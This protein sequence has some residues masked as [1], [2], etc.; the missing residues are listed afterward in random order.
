MGSDA[1]PGSAGGAFSQGLA[2]GKKGLFLFKKF[3]FLKTLKPAP[4]PPPPGEPAR[5]TPR[6]PPAHQTQKNALRD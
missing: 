1:Q 6:P 3:L 5:V 4:P 2:A